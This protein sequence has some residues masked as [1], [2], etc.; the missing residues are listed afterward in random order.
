[1]EEEN[2]DAFKDL[3]SGMNLSGT[4]LVLIVKKMLKKQEN[5]MKTIFSSSSAEAREERKRN[6]KQLYSL[7]IYLEKE[8][9]ISFPKLSSSFSS[10]KQSNE[11]YV[12][13][14]EH[15]ISL[16]NPL[17]ELNNHSVANTGIIGI[18]CEKH[19]EPDSNPYSVWCYSVPSEP[20]SEKYGGINIKDNCMIV[21]SINMETLPNDYIKQIY[22]ELLKLL[23]K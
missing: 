18:E 19:P 12:Y 7:L 4:R 8:K 11:I 21:V 23:K 14:L 1:M 9:L 17:R 5:F 15:K 10:E 2:N 6:L 16:Q 20:N 22:Q 3:T 13:I